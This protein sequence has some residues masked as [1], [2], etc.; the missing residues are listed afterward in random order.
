MSRRTEKVCTGCSHLLPISSFYI[1]SMGHPS[2]RC[3]SCHN[4]Y[5][6]ERGRYYTRDKRGLCVRCGSPKDGPYKITCSACN[7]IEKKLSKQRRTWLMQDLID[8]Y[9]GI[10]VCCGET[11]YIFLTLDHKNGGGSKERKQ[12]PSR[13]NY[14]Y[15][16]KLLEG[17][18]R[19]D[20]QVMCMNCN[21]GRYRNGGVCPHKENQEIDASI[22]FID[23]IV[24]SILPC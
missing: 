12:E 2:G 11:T 10:C 9:G 13:N 15:Y 7:S 21:W 20:L 8:K 5:H 16:K 18:I 17:P 1:S 6:K 14:T 23:Q 22:I 19:E 24:E 4:A 3:K